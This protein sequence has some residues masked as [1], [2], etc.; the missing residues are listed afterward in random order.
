MVSKHWA[1]NKKRYGLSVVAFIGLLITWFVFAI[2]TKLDRPMATEVQMVTFFL[3]LFAVGTFYAS[4]YFRD[5]G[6]KAK[7]SN[8][9]LVPAS[10][11]EK[12][13]CGLLFTVL[14]FFVVFTASFYFVDGLMVALSNSLS[15]PEGPAGKAP[16]INI[17]KV[18]ILRFNRDSTIN[19]LLF[20]FSVQSAFLLG[21][22]YFEKYS[23]IKTIISGFVAGFILFCLMYFFNEML[24]PGD[25]P[26]GF[27]TA[28]RVR[29]DGVNDHLVQVPDWIGQVF[30]FLA[31]Y[32]V[33]PFLWIVTYY[34]LKEKQV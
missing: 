1:D 13:L 27:L 33:A 28:Y 22:V 12:L 6:S 18:I 3:S 11:F 30:R 19:F 5:L 17:F 29:V 31:M 24:P 15:G 26:R 21:S 8:F 2:L 16:V 20:F 7:G 34:R 9:L 32:A 25:Y 14:L 10:A 4:Q 23:F